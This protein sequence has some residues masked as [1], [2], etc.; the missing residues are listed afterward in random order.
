MPYRD[1][2]LVDSKRE[3]MDS[4]PKILVNL[5]TA[6]LIWLFGVLVFL[7][8]AR[9][10]KD[11]TVLGLVGLEKVI[12]AIIIIA[13]AIILVKILR[14][15]R[16]ITDALAGLVALYFTEETS[17]EKLSK[18][19]VA[20]RGLGYVVV[21]VI[22]Y[23]FFLPFFAAIFTAFAGIILIVILI[24]ALMV[25]FRVGGAFS[26]DIEKKAGELS[27]KVEELK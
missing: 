20:F 4:F 3:V 2:L 25:L 6:F 8:L 1:E 16:D 17:E 23:L 24:W 10:L 19:R 12:A 13:I 11:P 7:P 27:R 18:Y 21:V 26:E 14:E 5:G 15:V 9:S 22:A